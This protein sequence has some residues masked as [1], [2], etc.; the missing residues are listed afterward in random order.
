MGAQTAAAEKKAFARA[1]RSFHIA[2]LA[3]S[4]FPGSRH[5]TE[6]KDRPGLS[7]LVITAPG[8]GGRGVGD[9]QIKK[10]VGGALLCCVVVAAQGW[11]WED[12]RKVKGGG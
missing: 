1:A 3:F 2:L 4:R 10:N 7:R 5:W 9:S 8:G 6:T 11:G 12:G